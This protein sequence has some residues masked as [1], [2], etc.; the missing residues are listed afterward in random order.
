MC[1]CVRAASKVSVAKKYK[2]VHIFPFLFLTQKGHAN[3]SMLPVC[4][5]VVVG[6]PNLLSFLPQS[7]HQQGPILRHA[8]H[9]EAEDSQ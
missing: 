8:G 2:K 5:C 3:V 7:E 1:L 9:K 4:V 6:E